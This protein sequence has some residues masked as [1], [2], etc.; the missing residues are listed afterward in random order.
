ML[1]FLIFS[2]HSRSVLLLINRLCSSP[3]EVIYK[4]SMNDFRFLFGIEFQT[5]FQEQEESI[6]RLPAE[7]YV[8]F[9]WYC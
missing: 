2:L 3:Y 1:V 9:R 6:G 8:L 4:V 5:T 7:S